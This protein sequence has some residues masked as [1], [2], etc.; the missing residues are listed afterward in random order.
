MGQQCLGW[1]NCYSAIALILS[2]SLS[3]QV[4]VGLGLTL[5]CQWFFYNYIHFFFLSVPTFIN[6]L[7]L[8]K[9]TWYQLS[10]I[11]NIPVAKWEDKSG[12]FVSKIVKY[13][14]R[15]K[16]FQTQQLC[17]LLFLPVLPF[18]LLYFWCPPC[19]YRWRKAH[20][21]KDIILKLIQNF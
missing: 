13:N 20:S 10:D 1:L 9:Y 7:D 12:T 6:S 3:S 11:S 2:P 5:W 4:L 18:H 14:L 21:Y 19:W 8:A 15:Q 17:S 16:Q